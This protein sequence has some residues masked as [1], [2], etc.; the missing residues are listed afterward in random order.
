MWSNRPHDHLS[1]PPF[2]LSTRSAKAALM[3]R[4]KANEIMYS[5]YGSPYHGTHT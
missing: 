1:T 5:S 4:A 2:P 3:E